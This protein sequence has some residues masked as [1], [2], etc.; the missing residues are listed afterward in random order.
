MR[1]GTG[2]QAVTSFLYK[3]TEWPAEKEQK[4]KEQQKAL[5]EAAK[6][7]SQKGPLV[8]G[9]I[10]KS[11]RKTNRVRVDSLE[12]G[13]G[14]RQDHL[15]RG[16]DSGLG[17]LCCCLARYFDSDAGVDRNAGHSLKVVL[18]GNSS[19]L[20][21]LDER[22]GTS[23]EAADLLVNTTTGEYP[24]DRGFSVKTST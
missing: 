9:G 2:P 16:N 6:K 21:M 3:I 7:A 13:H 17:G 11:A 5:A 10:K 1:D 22:G 8:T 23:N 14:A 24:L 19:S 12:D 20:E 15:T 18:L 4:Q